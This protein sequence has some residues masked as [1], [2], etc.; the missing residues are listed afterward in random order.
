[1]TPV[2]YDFVADV[3]N[4]SKYFIV[5][6]P[7]GN[8]GSRIID[9]TVIDNGQPYVFPSSATYTCEGVNGAGHG[10][11][12]T[13][14][15]VNGKI[16]I[17]ISNSMISY[18]GIG[19]YRVEIMVDNEIVS[20]FNFH[21]S[22]EEVPLAPG[23]IIT[24]DDFQTLTDA[25]GVVSDFNK[26]IVGST[27]PDNSTGN[28][29]DLYLNT[30]NKAVY[31]KA[32]G[33]WNY[34][35]T[36]GTQLYVAY[37]DSAAGANMSFTYTGQSYLGLCNSQALT[38][39]INPALYTWIL[40]A[41]GDNMK[42]SDYGGSD[43][44]TVEQADHIKGEILL[45]DIAI[46]ANTTTDTT[47]VVVNNQNIGTSTIIEDVYTTTYGLNPISASVGTGT[48]TLIFPA[49]STASTAMVKIWNVD[50]YIYPNAT[51][52]NDQTVPSAETSN[53]DF[54]N[55]DNSVEA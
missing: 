14:T 19:K 11:T 35:C 4:H 48:L 3:S 43:G 39:P 30:T 23:Q 8:V 20:S 10:V 36:L 45:S 53:I 9:V 33:V 40:V 29:L 27:E 46:P 7:Q 5:P 1:M 13:C 34:Q 50:N 17:P 31:Q 18:K 51:E 28:N 47:T 52:W 54:E 37:A 42:R 21:I 41:G 24:T 26:W 55:F 16:R 22:V 32:G 49:L 12:V 38:Q 25:L 6:L 15:L 44:Y 2:V